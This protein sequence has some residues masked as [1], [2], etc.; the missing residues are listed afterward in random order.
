MH[1]DEDSDTELMMLPTDMALQK[2]PH[3]SPWVKKYAED[4]DLFFKDFATVFT[5]LL[6]LGIQRD[7]QGSIT[8]S[9]NE[10]GG[11]IAAPKKTSKPGKPEK[12]SD[13]KV[14]VDEAEPLARENRK[15]R[16][17]L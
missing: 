11:Y 4:K 12:S 9:D 1:Y 3:F 8:N 7:E 14:G 16:A 15:F 17:R 2:D 5:K 10:F 6:E 13:D